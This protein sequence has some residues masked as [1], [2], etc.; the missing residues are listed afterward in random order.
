MEKIQHRFSKRMM[1]KGLD[2]ALKL[3]AKVDELRV[4]HSWDEIRSLLNEPQ[5]TYLYYLWRS[6]GYSKQ[7]SPNN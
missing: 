2:A 6:A 1:A 4:N 3:A 5:P 7:L